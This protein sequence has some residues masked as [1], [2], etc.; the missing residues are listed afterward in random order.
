VA[1]ESLML[2]SHSLLTATSAAFEVCFE[3]G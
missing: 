1:D 3:F 2:G